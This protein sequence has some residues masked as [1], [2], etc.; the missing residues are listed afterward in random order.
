MKASCKFP[1][2]VHHQSQYERS[3]LLLILDRGLFFLIEAW[4]HRLKDTWKLKCWDNIIP[5]FLTVFIRRGAIDFL[6][7]CR[8]I[9]KR[10]SSKPRDSCCLLL[11][12]RM[13]SVTSQFSGFE[14]ES[15]VQICGLDYER[16]TIGHEGSYTSTCGHWLISLWF[17][18]NSQW[19]KCRRQLC[20]L[21][22][23]EQW[24]GGLYWMG[25]SPETHF[26]GQCVPALWPQSR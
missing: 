11:N 6:S 3:P 23:V 4:I 16:S 12:Y 19:S 5:H 9:I 20:P 14:T 25:R 8:Q 21:D 18:S 15:P 26:G 13:I 22:Q 24:D 17:S 7:Y 10:N 1:P 2:S